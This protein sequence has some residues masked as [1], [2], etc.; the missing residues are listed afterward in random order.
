M[1]R[2]DR[3]TSRLRAFT[4]VELLVVIAIIGILV[5]LLLPAVQAAR[6]AARRCQCENNLVQ[7]GL[8]LH[9]FEFNSE[10]LPSGTT[11]P[12]GPI[13]S[14]PQGEHVSWIVRILPYIDQKVVYKHFDLKAGAYADVNLPVRNQRLSV[15]T[16]PSFW[17]TALP[18]VGELNIYH[19]DYAGCHHH[20][21][22]PIDATNTGLL[23][24]NSRIRFSDIEDGSSQTL[25]VGEKLSN[26][27]DLGWVSGTRATLRNTG[28][29]PLQ[30]K[31]RS[32]FG[33]VDPAKEASAQEVGSFGSSH[34]GG[35][36]FVFGDGSVHFISHAIEPKT[37]Q[38]LGNR[39]DGE[40]MQS[41]W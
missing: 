38:Q 29:T 35:C 27:T 21:E 33:G 13:K 16:C 4:L 31:G 14:E 40:L 22:A 10:H 26:E 28:A 19:S 41:E 1:N 37:F 3:D 18:Q 23:F 24:L 39:S 25:L 12:T 11:N 7:I 32:E 20:E 17:E 15:L 5:G 2:S 36:Q 9:H 30:P 34:T 6:E 8:A